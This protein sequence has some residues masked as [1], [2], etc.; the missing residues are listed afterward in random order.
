MKEPARDQGRIGDFAG[1]KIVPDRLTQRARRQNVLISRLV[2][3]PAAH[4]HQMFGLFPADRLHGGAEVQEGSDQDDVRMRAGAQRAGAVGCRHHNRS[5]RDNVAGELPRRVAQI[6]FG[7]AREFA[8]NP[9]AVAFAGQQNRRML[10]PQRERLG[11][12]G[13]RNDRRRAV[14]QRGDDRAGGAK[15]IKNDTQGIVQVAPGQR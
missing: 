14:R 13:H 15:H 8:A 7:A 4:D 12:L 6:E 11:N 5:A 10:M 3:R 2:E 1:A 9:D